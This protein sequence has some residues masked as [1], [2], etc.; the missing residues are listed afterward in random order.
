MDSRKLRTREG[1]WKT[2]VIF[3]AQ[4]NEV[5]RLEEAVGQA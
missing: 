2:L 3:L 1:S 5:K 4:D